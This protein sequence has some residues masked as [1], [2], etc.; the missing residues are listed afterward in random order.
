VLLVVGCT[1]T[2]SEVPTASTDDTDVGPEDFT[3]TTPREDVFPV[4]AVRHEEATYS[5][6]LTQVP[7]PESLGV[8]VR[9]DDAIMVGL[10][11]DWPATWCVQ[12]P[13]FR[14]RFDPFQVRVDIEDTLP[15]GTDD[16]DI[17]AVYESFSP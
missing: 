6:W 12:A 15:S 4:D 16:A 1:A 8:F 7:V 2:R 11:E 13:C 5:V 17:V 14:W 3:G 10:R 9:I